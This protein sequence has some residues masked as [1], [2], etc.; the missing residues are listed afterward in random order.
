MEIVE[1]ERAAR[2]VMVAN[3]KDIAPF[4]VEVWREASC[5]ALWAG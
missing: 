5:G 4:C 3:V 2:R 1:Y